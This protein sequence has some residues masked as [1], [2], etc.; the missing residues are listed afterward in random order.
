MVSKDA[1]HGGHFGLDEEAKEAVHDQL[2]QQ[3]K[4]FFPRGIYARVEHWRCEV[5]GVDRINDCQS[6]VSIF[7]IN[8]FIQFFRFSSEWPL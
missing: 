7:A 3:P 4:D 6:A 8:H 1:L 5:G 2:A